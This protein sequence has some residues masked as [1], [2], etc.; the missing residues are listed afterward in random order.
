MLTLRF[1]LF[2]RQYLRL[3]VGPTALC[4]PVPWRSFLLHC[5]CPS[6]PPFFLLVFVFTLRVFRL[7]LFSCH[8]DEPFDYLHY[9]SHYPSI[10]CS[11]P[12]LG[13]SITF[14]SSCHFF[15]VFPFRKSLAS[16]LFP[17]SVHLLLSFFS[18]PA[19]SNL[20]ISCG[21]CA[22]CWFL[23]LLNFLRP[24]PSSIVRLSHPTIARAAGDSQ[25]ALV[26]SC[27]LRRAVY[28]RIDHFRP[29]PIFFSP[30]IYLRSAQS[31][32]PD[33]GKY[34]GQ[35]Y[36]ICRSNRREEKLHFLLA[37]WSRLKPRHFR[38]LVIHTVASQKDAK[39]R[40]MFLPLRGC[41]RLFSHC[42]NWHP[43]SRCGWGVLQATIPPWA[44]VKIF[45]SSN[46][47]GYV[48]VLHAYFW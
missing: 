48:L 18:R 10:F 33:K 20:F 26:D 41:G 9:L 42:G 28:L 46:L 4:S 47:Y 12:S 7:S 37:I 27:L 2:M 1:H 40:G 5:S 6:F 24:S 36:E 44:S 14:V 3:T 23:I 19:H 43:P 39:K 11:I 38:F 31:W 34:A 45:K 29:P 32:K 16:C 35:K 25:F 15:F 13:I 21:T 8:T 17:V 30:S 22:P